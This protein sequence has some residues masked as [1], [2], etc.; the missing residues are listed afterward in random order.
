MN[1]IAS[2]LVSRDLRVD[3]RV[4]CIY[5]IKVPRSS[6]RTVAKRARVSTSKA[7]IKKKARAREQTKNA[8]TNKTRGRFSEDFL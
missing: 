7:L 2:R 1:D 6:D 3:C 5:G 8:T 4:D